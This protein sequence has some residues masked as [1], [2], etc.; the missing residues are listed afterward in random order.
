MSTVIFLFEL[1]SSFL[2]NDDDDDDDDDDIH[3]NVVFGT[4]YLTKT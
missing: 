4:N 1:P 3:Q 2:K